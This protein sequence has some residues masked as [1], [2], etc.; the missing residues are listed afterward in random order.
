MT[1]AVAVALI[2]GIPLAL[3]SLGGFIVMIR[4]QDQVQKKVETVDSK[5]DAN[6]V[7]TTQTRD[8]ADGRLTTVTAKMEEVTA[9]LAAS[10]ANVA[11]MVNDGVAKAS[12]D[13]LAKAASASAEMI[14]KA[15]LTA[16][17]LLAQAKNDA[18][19]LLAQAEIGATSRRKTGR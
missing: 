12:T 5:V 13:V 7:I 4:R 15:E 6:T 9:K 17:A 14:A 11:R 1:D 3:T 19:L 8:M 18:V 16:A 2:T 10:E